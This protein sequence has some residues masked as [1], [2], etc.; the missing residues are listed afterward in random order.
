ME[1][2]KQL[3]LYEYKLIKMIKYLKAGEHKLRVI[4]RLKNWYLT[5]A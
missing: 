2:Q 1:N 3:K 4:S 5:A